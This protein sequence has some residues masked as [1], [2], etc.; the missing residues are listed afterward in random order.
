MGITA[1]YSLLAQVED[2][3]LF[4]KHLIEEYPYLLKDWTEKT[5]KILREAAEEYA[6]GDSDIFHDTYSQMKSIF[7]EN[8]YHED[9]FYK[10]M[11]LMVYAYYEGTIDFLKKETKL[12]D[13]IDILWALMDF[14]RPDEEALDWSLLPTVEKGV[15]RLGE[16]ASLVPRAPVVVA[17]E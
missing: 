2:R 17:P 15:E 3:A 7:Y 8:D 5:D 10:A 14:A 6:E 4:L 9:A 12:D 11:I 1:R 13:E 16:L